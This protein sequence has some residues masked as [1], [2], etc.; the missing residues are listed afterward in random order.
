M[1]SDDPKLNNLS[2]DGVEFWTACISH[3]GL[4]RLRPIGNGSYLVN[5]TTINDRELEV[6][7][8]HEL[9]EVDL[10]AYNEE[11]GRLDG[12]IAL[13]LNERIYIAPNCCGDIGDLAGWE[14]VGT[15]AT[16]EWKQL[17]IGHP[18]VY[19]RVLDD[20]VEFSEYTE[21]E[22]TEHLPVKVTVSKYELMLEV[23]RM[24]EEQD[25]FQERVQ[26]VLEKM[27]IEHSEAIAEIMTGNS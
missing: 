19:Y 22:E 16:G 5:L 2:E 6:I 27:G 24:R 26:R 8:Q 4:G 13:S 25:Y 15:E 12:G 14:G 9:K 3:S 17:W 7:L 18:W 1:N 10:K 21:R 20:L 23:K 11:V